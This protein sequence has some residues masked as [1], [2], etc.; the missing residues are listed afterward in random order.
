MVTPCKN[1][2]DRRPATRTEPSCH[3]GC[4]RYKAWKDYIDAKRKDEQKY[5]ETVE[6]IVKAIHKV[7]SVQHRHRRR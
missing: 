2:P 4:E 3:A 7:K 1:C 6:L 5:N